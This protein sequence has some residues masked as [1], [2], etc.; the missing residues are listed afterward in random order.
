MLE[1]KQKGHEP[2]RQVRPHAPPSTPRCEELSNDN[3]SILQLGKRLLHTTHGNPCSGRL[4]YCRSSRGG[5]GE[6]GSSRQCF[7]DRQSRCAGV[8]W[9]CGNRRREMPCCQPDQ[10]QDHLSSSQRDLYVPGLYP[11]ESPEWVL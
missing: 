11:R 9:V 8:E 2:H 6:G 3:D 5:Q 1:H 10:W 4:P 7:Q